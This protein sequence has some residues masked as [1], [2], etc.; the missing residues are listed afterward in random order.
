ML[1]FAFVIGALLAFLFFFPFKFDEDDAH[2]ARGTRILIL[3]GVLVRVRD[4][5]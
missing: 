5:E 2:R 3:Q 1:P 4:F